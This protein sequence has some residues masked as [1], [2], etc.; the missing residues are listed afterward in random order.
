MRKRYLFFI[1]TI[2][3]ILSHG[4]I[5]AQKRKSNPS[6]S[7][8]KTESISPEKQNSEAFKSA[9]NTVGFRK[10]GPAK[11]SGRIVDIVVNPNNTSQYFVA[12]AYG[13]VWKTENGGVTFQPIFDNY[14]TQS[15]G[16]L[17][18]DPNNPNILW[19]GTGENNNQRSVGYGN[20]IYKSEDGGKSFTHLG[21]G[22]S[23]HIGMISINPK[24]SNEVLVAAYGPVWNS[25]GDRG[26][27]QT[28]DGGKT[29]NRIL[30]ISEETG[31]NEIHR[32]PFNDQI[33]YA[34]AHQRRRHEWTYLGGG[35][36]S[37]LHI[38]RDGGKTW[39]KAT[40]GFPQGELGRISC[41]TAKNTSG[42]IYTIVEGKKDQGGVYA[43]TDF[44]VS[45]KKTNA[46]Q[47]SGNYYQEIMV[48]PKNDKRL[49][50]MDTYLHVSEDG[51]ITVKPF[52]EDQKHVDN[53]A[54]WIDPN[55]G[56][57]LLVG[58][59]GGLYE[60]FENGKTWHFK[61]N[62]SITQFYRVSVDNSKPFYNV[63]G[64]TQD[65]FSLGG[66]SRNNTANGIGNDEWFVTVG[67]DGF[68]SQIDPVNPDIVYAQWQYGGLVRFNKK[69]GDNVDIRP[70]VKPDET[71]L[72][73]NWDAPLLISKY[74][75]KKLYFAANKVFSSLNQ[76]DSWNIIS[77]DL[78]RNFD[79]N[80]IPVMGKQWGIET[81]AKNQST[82]IYGNI[83]FMVEGRENQLA[84]GT[85][86]GKLHITNNDGIS[87]NEIVIP[88]KT[89]DIPLYSFEFIESKTSI[90]K[91]AEIYPLISSIVFSSHNSDILYVAFDNHR[92]GD[93]KPHFYKVILSTNTWVKMGSDL[94][95]NG[96]V[97]C[98]FEDPKE[99][100]I[101][102]VGT[103]F[104]L[105]VSINS[106]ENFI[107]WSNG[108]P[109]I[110]IKDIAY[111]SEA[112]DVVL[113]TFGRGFVVCDDYEMI[114]QFAKNENKK[115]VVN[116]QHQLF[117]PYSKL[118][119]SGNAYQGDGRFMGENLSEKI[120]IR[121]KTGKK[122]GSIEDNRKAFEK[123]AAPK[124]VIYPT[125]E[126]IV[127]EE[128]EIPSRFFLHIYK[129]SKFVATINVANLE[130]WQ[131]VEWNGRYSITNSDLN[132]KQSVQW[133][134]YVSP[135][136]YDI[137]LYSMDYANS[138]LEILDSA[139][140][141]IDFLM[142]PIKT[143]N[144]D[145][146]VIVKKIQD[147]DKKI[148][149]VIAGKKALNALERRLAKLEVI[150]KNG[151]NESLERTPEK[152]KLYSD[153]KNLNV[154][155]Y[156]IKTILYGNSILA[157]HEFETNRG[158]SGEINN[159]F[160]EFGGSFQAPTQTHMDLFYSSLEKLNSIEKQ[161][162]LLESEL[163]TLQ[164]KLF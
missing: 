63:Y 14:S 128:L 96:P 26:I 29:W 120:K 75:H 28:L 80:V 122:F 150:W 111:Q 37:G 30:H 34:T 13:G 123:N 143:S 19:V 164:T 6:N 130:N 7:I 102:L 149:D 127:L 20:G 55:N 36:E 162:D 5:Q 104:G 64:G 60:T 8:P 11:T 76:G 125:K 66:P 109:P 16:C 41:A 21:L 103:E 53:H 138:N 58:C 118:G 133:G 61:E 146:S 69:W 45:W 139:K 129:N 27:Y 135:G 106:G 50:F 95:T 33:L 93:L 117:I 100:K 39:Q 84:V 94:P 31:F 121:I 144:S 89:L 90:S 134:P 145:K 101:I 47:T 67:G 91:S 3:F 148:Y 112:D 17:A 79:R 15:I 132:E 119:H 137:K 42:L 158:I 142:E 86:D 74:N 163:N 44:G 88:W 161:L 151:I 54:I 87:W 107:A 131:T 98:L 160:Y 52:P 40:G 12:A 78:S 83:T 18:L 154:K 157:G 71:P 62:I 32:D 110:A 113:A 108:L 81:V 105:F 49:F 92:Q 70:T 73:W 4:S 56:N 147:R 114:R 141:E 115:L 77:P 22:K 72:R 136:N 116:P 140:I 46:F 59:D 124:E 126:Q 48:D 23:M 156:D 99:G 10:I 51:G 82:S 153:W 2:G 97:K 1:P 38:S 85:D 65:N 159:S 35:P 24:N 43:S 25:G 9:L 152:M 155:I 68:K 57:H